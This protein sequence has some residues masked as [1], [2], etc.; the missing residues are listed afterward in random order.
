MT[1]TIMI[2]FQLL[3][4]EG[5]SS[6]LCPFLCRSAVPFTHLI[7]RGDICVQPQRLGKALALFVVLVSLF[8]DDKDLSHSIFLVYLCLYVLCLSFGLSVS[9]ED[10]THD[11]PFLK[12]ENKKKWD[13]LT[14]KVPLM[15]F[16][17]YSEDS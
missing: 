2:C 9:T 6:S 13:I 10:E 3:R 7:H 12:L 8:I 4:T 14:W 5:Y 15:W 11:G 1:C 17:T 16:C